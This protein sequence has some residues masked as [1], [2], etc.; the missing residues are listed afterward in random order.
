MWEREGKKKEKRG[1]EGGRGNRDRTRRRAVGRRE[2]LALR[3]ALRCRG[4]GP[5]DSFFPGSFVL[6]LGGV[7]GAYSGV[8]RGS[9]GTAG[10]QA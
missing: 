6:D 7:G 2:E 4:S 9:M 5:I 10:A 1:G 8:P 3:E